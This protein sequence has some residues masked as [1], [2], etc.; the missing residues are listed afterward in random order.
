[1]VCDNAILETVVFLPETIVFIVFACLVA[2]FLSTLYRRTDWLCAVSVA[3]T[4]DLTFYKIKRGDLPGGTETQNRMFC[5]WQ[6]DRDA[7]N[8][9]TWTKI[10]AKEYHEI[11][12][13]IVLRGFHEDFQ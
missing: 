10:G 3:T 7:Q 6:D 2:H 13:H 5:S 9:G 8:T 4:G 11:T 1:M 12:G